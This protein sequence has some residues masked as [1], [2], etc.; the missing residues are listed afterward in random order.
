MHSITN[1]RAGG[2][3]KIPHSCLKHPHCEPATIMI[4][5]TPHATASKQGTQFATSPHSHLA[6]SNSS[7]HY[8][9]HCPGWVMASSTTFVCIALG[10]LHNND[11]RQRGLIAL[12]QFQSRSH[13]LSSLSTSSPCQTRWRPSS[14][15]AVHFSQK[16]IIDQN[17]WT[18]GACNT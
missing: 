13:S 18:L 4:R 14:R 2:I 11:A 6:T 12:Q 15:Q 7:V 10:L 17:Q 16:D 3:S 9:A 1:G 8:N 5:H